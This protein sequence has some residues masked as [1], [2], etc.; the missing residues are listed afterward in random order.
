MHQSSESLAADLIADKTQR[1]SL[2]E[3]Q[4]IAEY[5]LLLLLLLPTIVVERFV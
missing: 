3:E 5:L 2:P 1:C 4:Q